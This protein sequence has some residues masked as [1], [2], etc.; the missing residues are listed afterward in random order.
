VGL[1]AQRLEA[2]GGHVLILEHG[3]RALG[4]L[5][6]GVLGVEAIPPPADAGQGLVR[7]VAQASGGAVTLL[8]AEALAAEA[9]RLFSAR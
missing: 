9:T 1:A 2:P 4:F 6:G 5:I 3:K 7:G 8:G